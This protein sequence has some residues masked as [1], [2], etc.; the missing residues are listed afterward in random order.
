[1]WYVRAKKQNN[2][3]KG[4]QNIHGIPVFIEYLKGETRTKTNE[5]GKTWSRKMFAAYGRISKTKGADGMCID[6]YVGED[7]A[8]EKVFIVDQV[9][10]EGE[11]DEHKCMLGCFSMK[12]AKETY[13]KNYPKDFK[14]GKITEFTI[15]EFKKWIESADKSKQA[16]E[17]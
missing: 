11:F 15:S 16:S 14:V 7:P 8:S 1:M 4:G 2:L 12:N 9:D 13:A 3:E 5:E 10:K 17:L 6:I